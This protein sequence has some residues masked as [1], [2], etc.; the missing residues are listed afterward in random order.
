[1][2]IKQ[3]VIEAKYNR[4]NRELFLV[5]HIAAESYHLW[6]TKCV[7]VLECREKEWMTNIKHSKS[8]K[9]RSDPH[10][11]KC[12]HF[13]IKGLRV[14]E[15]SQKYTIWLVDTIFLA[16]MKSDVV[17]WNVQF[18]LTKRENNH[19][20]EDGRFSEP[21]VW[22]E[23]KHNWTLQNLKKR[24]CWDFNRL[25]VSDWWWMNGGSTRYCGDCFVFC[26]VLL[27][28]RQNTHCVVIVCV[29]L[30]MFLCERI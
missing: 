26:C 22:Q 24:F 18:R 20:Y 11:S 1:M 4:S 2:I 23:G 28:L 8:T 29:G 10:F 19:E 17:K 30:G 15:D 16:M 5:E 6:G 21:I 12:F 7:L 27:L 14:I 25:E 9:W 13:I 3:R